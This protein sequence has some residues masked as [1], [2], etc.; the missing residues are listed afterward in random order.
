MGT[1]NGYTTNS[2]A[3]GTRW[4]NAAFTRALQKSLSRAESIQFLVLIHI[5]LRSIL[6]ID[7]PSRLGLPNGLFLVGL[8]NSMAYGTRSFNTAFTRALQ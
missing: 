7:L 6:N 3:Y 5:S 1:G 4:F 2:M 8:T